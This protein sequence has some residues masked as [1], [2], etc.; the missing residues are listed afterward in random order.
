VGRSE[1]IMPR[2][3]LYLSEDTKEILKEACR[4]TGMKPSPTIALALAEF[5]Q[6]YLDTEKRKEVQ[7]SNE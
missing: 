3:N 7:K 6:S 5:V 4:Q 2:M 1:L